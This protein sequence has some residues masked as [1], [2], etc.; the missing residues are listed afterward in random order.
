MNIANGLVRLGVPNPADDRPCGRRGQLKRTAKDLHACFPGNGSHELERSFSFARAHPLPWDCDLVADECKRRAAI[1]AELLDLKTTV[2]NRNDRVRLTRCRQRMSRSHEELRPTFR[3]RLGREDVAGQ[4]LDRDGDAGDGSAFQIDDPAFDGQ[5][6]Y[7]LEDNVAGWITVIKRLPVHPEST[8]AGGNLHILPQI[9]S[10]FA[11]AQGERRDGRLAER[12]LKSAIGGSG[13]PGNKRG[14]APRPVGWA[15]TVRRTPGRRRPVCR[16]ASA[17][18]R[19]P[20]RC[21]PNW[22]VSLARWMQRQT[23]EV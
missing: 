13:R 4:P 15:S 17:R 14:S 21:R 3:R 1:A 7:E 5:V 19:E 16:R 2:G 10:R 8:G 9:S 11:V 23:V 6:G 12:H 18:D 20:R 22:V